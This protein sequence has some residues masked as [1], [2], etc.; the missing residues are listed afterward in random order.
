SALLP[1]HA[2]LPVS[3][4]RLTTMKRAAIIPQ[5]STSTATDSTT[6]SGPM[7]APPSSRRHHRPSHREGHGRGA[8]S[9]GTHIKHTSRPHADGG[10]RRFARLDQPSSLVRRTP[11]WQSAL[12]GVTPHCRR[13]YA[14]NRSRASKRSVKRV[15]HA[16][17]VSPCQ[18]IA[19]RLMI[20][21]S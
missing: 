14:S 12:R 2:A 5:V 13:G 11:V 20:W 8:E 1:L 18:S 7:Y 21:Y 17:L 6:T 4:V 19:S 15:R 16:T 3:R 10:S 9:P